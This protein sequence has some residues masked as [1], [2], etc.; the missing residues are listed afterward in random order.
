MFSDSIVAGSGADGYSNTQR[1]IFARDVTFPLTDPYSPAGRAHVP[2]P[3][4]TEWPGQANR[5]GK[6]YYG[7][8]AGVDI[9]ADAKRVTDNNRNTGMAGIFDDVGLDFMGSNV[10]GAG[11]TVIGGGEST[12]GGTSIWDRIFGTIQTTLPATISAITGK[13][14]SGY[15]SQQNRQG[16]YAPAGYVYDANGNLISTASAAQ[17]AGGLGVAGAT[18]ANS[19]S[20]FVKQNPLLILG[21]VAA[22]LLLMTR[23]PG[24]R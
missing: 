13:R 6:R 21:G 14:D 3:G 4:Y 22:I 12:G 7:L 16:V 18:A 24:R 11:G 9:K 19:I 2:V 10:P 5:L 1:T 15:Y 20:N 8:A 23:P 17:L